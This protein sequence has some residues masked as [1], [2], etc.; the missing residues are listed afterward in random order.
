M[1]FRIVFSVF[2]L[3]A[4]M[5]VVQAA[6]TPPASVPLPTTNT[7]TI[8]ASTVLSPGRYA[9]RL[10]PNIN[11]EMASRI[12]NSLAGI[13]G[14]DKVTTNVEDSSI[15]FTIKAVTRIAISDIQK[16]V[17]RADHGAVI[18]VPV[19]EGSGTTDPGL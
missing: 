8:M 12:K 3:S 14:V 17:V 18:S 10:S 11:G 2:V 7:T 6:D 15:H 5:S 16:A 4:G 13:P 9:S 19:L 1:N